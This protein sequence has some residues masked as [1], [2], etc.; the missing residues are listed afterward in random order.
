MSRA[1]PLSP[2]GPFV[3]CY[4]VTF[5]FTGASVRLW[6]IQ[7]TISKALS[8]PPRKLHDGGTYGAPKHVEGEFVPLLCM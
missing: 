7:R 6:Y 8:L 4:R 1:V 3:T 2:S 5:I